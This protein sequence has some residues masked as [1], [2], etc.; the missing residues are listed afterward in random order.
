[1]VALEGAATGTPERALSSADAA[2]YR[3]KAAGRG[4]WQLDATA[5]EPRRG[6]GEQLAKRTRQLAVANAVGAR[7]AGMTDVQAIADA[8]VEELRRAFGYHLCAV[9]RLRPDDRVEAIAVRGTHSTRSSCAAGAN[10]AT[11]G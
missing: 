2:M 1:V 3:V 4:G 5:A 6:D 7:L 9:I 10:P 8:T 11:K